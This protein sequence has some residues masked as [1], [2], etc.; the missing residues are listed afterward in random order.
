MS[1]I[2]KIRKNK[3]KNHFSSLF[4]IAA[5]GMKHHHHHHGHCDC[6]ECNHRHHEEEDEVVE[7]DDTKNSSTTV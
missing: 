6:A 7:L 3:V 4:P 1:F 2:R 5:S